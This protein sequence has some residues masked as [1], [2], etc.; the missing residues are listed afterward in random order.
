MGMDVPILLQV[1]VSVF[2]LETGLQLD[3]LQKFGDYE[4]LL[5][6]AG[7]AAGGGVSFDKK[8]SWRCFYRFNY[9]TGYYSHMAGV[10]KS[11]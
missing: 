2:S 4:A 1:D 8:R 7:F 5:F 10:R 6:N 9:G 11:F 3:M